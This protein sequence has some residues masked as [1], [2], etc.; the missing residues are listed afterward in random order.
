MSRKQN[1]KSQP[2][3]I[4]D[5]VITTGG[6]FDMLSKCLDALYLESEKT[7][8]NIYIIDNASP[9]EERI[10]NEKLFFPKEDSRNV[11]EFQ[12][13][14]LQ[15]HVGFPA[16]NNE[17]ARMGSAPLIMF[18]NDDVELHEGTV[19]KIVK[20]LDDPAIGVV[21]IKLLFS[22]YR[23]SPYYPQGKVQHVGLALDIRG[24]CVHPLSG[25]SPDNPKTKVSRDVIG[26]TGACLTIRRS[27]FNRVGGFSPEYGEG[28]WEDV[29]LC[30]KARQQGAR[31]WMN[32]EATGYHYTNATVEKTKRGFPVGQN[33]LLFQS[34]WGD[35]GLMAWT[36]AEFL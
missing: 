24:D 4:L 18:L 23:N 30:F 20:S 36:V 14:R 19:Q 6:R 22:P 34:K 1:H 7:P 31:V 33:R 16:S 15:N 9:A 26:V 3:A 32:C 12:S 11:V 28:T 35:S 29:D 17:G 13:K 21:G 5:V 10:Q 25:W 8:L 27:L 2:K